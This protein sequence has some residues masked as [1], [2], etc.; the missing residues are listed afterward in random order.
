MLIQLIGIEN[1]AELNGAMKKPEGR[2]EPVFYCTAVPGYA[3]ELSGA[4]LPCIFVEKTGAKAWPGQEMNPEREKGPEQKD[5]GGSGVYGVDLVL[6]P[7]DANWESS[8]DNT[9][10]SGVCRAAA[11]LGQ[12]FLLK[13]WQRHYHIP[14]EIAETGRLLIRESLAEDLPQLLQIYA[15]ERDNP[16]VK[17]FSAEPDGELKAYIENRYPFYGYGLWS[18]VKRS[19]GRVI[20]RIGF[21]EIQRPK[22]ADGMCPEGKTA[23]ETA[24]LPELS[25]IIAEGERGKGYAR[26]AA[27]AVLTYGRQELGFTRAA[28]RTSSQNVASKRLAESLGFQKADKNGNYYEICLTG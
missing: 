19:D 25:Y 24:I 17:P 21:E 1:T 11:E 5:T 22:G 12:E 23:Q 8:E 14:W 26:E 15:A 10:V 13:L 16:D 9:G 4:G 7:E 3:R 6:C 28:L 2:K 18:V 27:A 20:G